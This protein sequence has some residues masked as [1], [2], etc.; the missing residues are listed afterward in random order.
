MQGAPQMES[1]C[2]GFAD[3]APSSPP[4]QPH[5]AVVSVGRGCKLCSFSRRGGVY[6]L[7]ARRR[8]RPPN[9]QAE[10]IVRH[11]RAPHRATSPS[12]SPPPGC[13]DDQWP[14]DRAAKIGR[15]ARAVL[16]TQS[17]YRYLSRKSP[18]RTHAPSVET[19]SS[20]PSGKKERK[21]GRKE[22]GRVSG[23]KGIELES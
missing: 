10:V 21:E 17:I 23:K 13:P 9:R 6:L 19:S 22:E 2:A 11:D 4:G 15:S 14:R 20:A 8:V 5:R 1:Q 16:L 7:D 3:S 12:P 18:M